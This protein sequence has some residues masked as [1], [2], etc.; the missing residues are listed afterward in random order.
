MERILV[1]LSFVTLSICSW[2]SDIVL[3]GSYQNDADGKIYDVFLT[4]TGDKPEKLE[5]NVRG[6]EASSNTVIVVEGKKNIR[7]WQ[8]CLVSMKDKYKKWLRLSNKLNLKFG[9]RNIEEDWPGTFMEGVM[10]GPQMNYERFDIHDFCFVDAFYTDSKKLYIMFYCNGFVM[11]KKKMTNN[12]AR[13]DREYNLKSHLSASMTFDTP[14]SFNALVSL[15]DEDY[16][17]GRI[18]KAK[19]AMK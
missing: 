15:F 13:Y 18:N 12:L 19:E 4:Y 14:E 16:L 7:N 8:K 3:A 1:L 5:I 9:V 11:T 6:T 17:K 10:S 2:A